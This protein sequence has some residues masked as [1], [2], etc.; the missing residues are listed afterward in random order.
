MARPAAGATGKRPAA[1]AAPP[2]AG[3]RPYSCEAFSVSQELRLPC[4]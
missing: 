3:A 1:A 2:A 4:S